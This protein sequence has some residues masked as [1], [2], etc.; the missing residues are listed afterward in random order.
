MAGG[1][2][3]SS[4]L[5]AVSPRIKA[6]SLPS[7]YRIEYGGEKENQD[8]TFPQMLGALAISLVAIFLVLLIQFRNISEP[9][10][11]MAS[12]PLA[13]LGVVS[14]LLVTRNP[15]G[16]TAFMGVISL[17]GIVVRNA[18]ILIDYVNEKIKEGHSLE[19]AAMEAGERRL[20]PIFLTT[21]T[22]AVGVTPMI[23][24]GS[25]LW[26]PLASVIAVGLI[27]SMFFTLLVVPVLFVVVRSRIGKLDAAGLAVVVA[28]ILLFSA[29]T[30]GAET[31]QLTL[32]QAVELALTRN[33]AVKIA[34]SRVD[35]GREKVASAVAD[36]LPL[37]SSETTY[38]STTDQQL[39]T[40]P[41]G[42]LGNIPGLGPFPLQ[43][44]SLDQGRKDFLIS[45]VTITQPITHLLKIW[46]AH[47]IAS[48]E[49]RGTEADL[50]KAETE[51]VFAVHKLYF[52]L[53][54]AG[55]LKEAA[56]AAIAAAEEA[57][58]ESKRG[59]ESG[60]LLDVS[61]TESRLRL[62]Q[63]R[64]LLLSTEIR[65]SDLKAE[66]NDLVGLAL[67]TDLVLSPV[68]PSGRSRLTRET[69]LD[70]AFSRNPEI[71]A[72]R[73][74]VNKAESA[75]NAAH[76]EYIPDI[77]AFG[78]YI[79]QDG[80]PFVAKN[81]GVFGLQMKWNIFDWGKRKAVAGQRASQVAQAK[82][83][84]K[85]LEKRIEVEVD[86]AYRKLEQT[87]MMKDVAREELALQKEHFRLGTNQLKA[88]TITE[89]RHAELSA[90]LK[91]SEY[92][93]LQAVLAFELALAEL[94]RVAGMPP[95]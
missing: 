15:F 53:L 65:I 43:D 35:E 28:G 47:N 92:N 79:Y 18:I 34:R 68:G 33:S 42:G 71:R 82:E 95:R 50:R 19:Q 30:A 38:M 91:K 74:Q 94:D 3:A 11:V 24:S 77:G 61:L 4:L 1:H 37:V 54:E 73:E 21:M 67:D 70:E 10:I 64:Q 8:E 17:S 31:R 13:L 72:A 9:L 52:G 40:V 51:I 22:A 86:K 25:S 75:L 23:L 93:D 32:P 56:E 29:G 88:G 41:A 87:R 39:V 36:Y 16:F 76:Y 49:K 85:S 48:A 80:V 60:A 89:A 12:I 20:R 2:Y 26:S 81:I 45:N 55:K 57:V 83:H 6:L 27:F 46:Q 66:M 14:G 69:Y 78:R 62:L 59:V 84:A 7:G 58:R 63:G 5:A 90:S 44:A